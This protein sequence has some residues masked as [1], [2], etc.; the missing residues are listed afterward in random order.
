MLTSERQ[1]LIKE[2]ALKNGEVSIPSLAQKFNVS[3]ETI[4]R[5]INILCEKKLL[6]KVHG[7][8]VPI[9]LSVREDA[10]E[11]RCYKNQMEKSII[12][13]YIASNL[14]EDND[15]IALS[16]GSTM[17][18]LA[19]SISKRN[20]VIVTNS[21]NVASILQN[22]IRQNAMS[23]EVIILGGSIQPDEHYTG[24]VMAVEMLKKFSFTKAFLSVSSISGRDLMTSNIDEGII[25]STMIDRS[26]FSCVAADFSKFDIRSTYTFADLSEIDAVVTD[27]TAVV[28]DEMQTL[29]KTT[30]VSFHKAA[31]PDHAPNELPLG[32][33]IKTE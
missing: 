8:A 16:S 1:R 32:N 18:I 4:R 14:I 5:D 9:Q 11:I 27:E 25:M 2:Q 7:G 29:F 17:E 33:P 21:I 12:G 15:S 28:T 3:I 13:E 31:S 22:R 23:G 10:Y 19:G 20:L 6:K 30:N 26:R 24:G